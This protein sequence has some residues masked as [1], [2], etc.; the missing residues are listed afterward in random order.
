MFVVLQ[1][2][3]RP[4]TEVS[5]VFQIILQYEGLGCASS[6]LQDSLAVNDCVIN[7]F[8]NQCGLKCTDIRNTDITANNLPVWTSC[9]NT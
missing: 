6:A 1:L 9:H 7:L 8:F 4:I 2:F 5:S 3:L